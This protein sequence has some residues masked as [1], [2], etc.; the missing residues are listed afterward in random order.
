MVTSNMFALP[1]YVSATC[2]TTP[3]REMLTST[4]FNC[5]SE[6]TMIKVCVA[7]A[8][9]WTGEPLS[10][11]LRTH[12]N[13]SLH[14][15]VARSCAGQDLGEVFGEET[16]GVPV[17]RTV[18][19]GIESADV[20]IDYTSHASIKEHTMLAIARGVHV[21]VGSSGLT[22]A[23]FDEI[24]KAAQE[25]AVGVVASGNFA[26][27]A[28]LAQAAALLAAR[29]LPAWEVIDYASDT[30]PDVPSGTARELAERLSEVHRPAQGVPLG[31][32][33]G[34]IEARGADVDGTR[35]HSL[36]LPGHTVGTDAVFGLPGE[37]LTIRFEAGSSASPYVDGTLLAAQKV[38]ELVGLV[39]GLDRLL[40]GDIG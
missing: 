31:Q 21:V 12:S 25:A 35:V 27:T 34:P 7:G 17:Y 22:G 33:A 40:L 28:A 24:D 11:A 36:R 10:R 1:P 23:D 19:E 3:L 30:K 38:P 9:G 18:A 14:S 20:L 2:N 6:A 26:V 32:T 5:E 15:A 13:L 8:T 39:R 16:W 4:A 29:Y 37:K